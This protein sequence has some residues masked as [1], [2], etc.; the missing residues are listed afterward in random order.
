[1]SD[2]FPIDSFSFL[3]SLDYLDLKRQYCSCA[4]S[5]EHGVTFPLRSNQVIVSASLSLETFSVIEKVVRPANAAFSPDLPPLRDT[6]MVT[7]FFLFFAIVHI[8]S[9][10]QFIDFEIVPYT[11]YR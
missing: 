6:G 3:F 2:K 4:F 10:K 1:M 8:P 11:C 7:L 9:N 5:D